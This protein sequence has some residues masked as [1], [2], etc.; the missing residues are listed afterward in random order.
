MIIIIILKFNVKN[1]YKTGVSFELGRLLTQVNIK[2]KI[3][4]II[5][6]KLDS[7]QDLEHGLGGSTLVELD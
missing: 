2:I 7:G 6:L 4:I 1:W 3:I 5:V